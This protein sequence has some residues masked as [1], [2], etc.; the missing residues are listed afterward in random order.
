MRPEQLVAHRG[1]QK[2]YPENSLLAYRKAIEAG[3]LFV[4]T[5]IQMSAD[6]V[7]VL[8]HDVEMMRLSGQSS[9]IDSIVA[10]RLQQIPLSEPRRFGEQFFDETIATLDQF[11]CL[12]EQFPQVTAY[13]EIKKEC[14]E[15][16]GGNTVAQIMDH[17]RPVLKQVVL[18]S[19]DYNSVQRARILGAVR[20]G[21][22]LKRWPDQ[23]LPMIGQ[24]QPDCFFCDVKRVPAGVDLAQSIAPVVVY[25]VGDVDQAHYWLQRGA[26]QVET[27]DI[28]S[29]LGGTDE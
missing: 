6:G 21:I 29:L 10:A 3:A 17:L 13:V 1:Y 26:A 8:Y 15:R 22:V 7:P 4:E 28:V 16:F 27:F 24:I 5:D 18:I 2:C 23:H 14:L 25:E 19:F 12:L 9:R 11:V 20:V